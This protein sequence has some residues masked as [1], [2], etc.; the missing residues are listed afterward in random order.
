M[1]R[2]AQIGAQI[3]RESR[4]E[5]RPRT[6]WQQQ[7]EQDDLKRQRIQ[8]KKDQLEA[9]TAKLEHQQR[10]EKEA[11]EKASGQQNAAP[12]QPKT[13]PITPFRAI[14]ED[15][16]QESKPPGT[17][18]PGDPEGTAKSEEYETEESTEVFLKG[19]SDEEIEL[20]DSESEFENLRSG[21]EEYDLVPEYQPRE[22]EEPYV[23]LHPQKDRLPSPHYNPPPKTLGEIFAVG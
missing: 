8:I 10:E 6:V 20:P 17:P 16:L 2:L 11:Q 7:K 21:D 3:R 1:N 9:R 18:L 19:A 14:N 5:E 13:S 4:R 22:E 12:S 15:K 23:S